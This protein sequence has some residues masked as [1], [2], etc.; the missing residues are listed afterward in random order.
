[1]S[2]LAIFQSSERTKTCKAHLQLLETISIQVKQIFI[3]YTFMKYL[4]AY[5]LICNLY[6]IRN[7]HVKPTNLFIHIPTQHTQHTQYTF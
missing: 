6:I 1:M 2:F 7:K 4:S 5:D 3:F